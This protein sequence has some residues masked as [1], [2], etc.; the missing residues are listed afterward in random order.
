MGQSS[1]REPTGGFTTRT[2]V[3]LS[4]PRVPLGTKFMLSYGLGPHYFLLKFSTQ[5]GKSRKHGSFIPKEFCWKLHRGIA[6]PGCSYKHQCFRCGNN[7]PISKRL[8]ASKQPAGNT[9][10]KTTS[11]TSQSTPNRTPSIRS[12]P[13]SGQN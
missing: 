4:R 6:C 10:P 1:L 3:P 11:F 12:T 9:G 7:H 13:I 8:Q 2:F 5:P